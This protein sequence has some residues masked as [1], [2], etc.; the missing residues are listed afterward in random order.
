MSL[1]LCTFAVKR[2]CGARRKAQGSGDCLNE[3]GASP[4]EELAPDI[5][6]HKDLLR[7]Q[8]NFTE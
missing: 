3:K 6:K 2:E 8:Q 5:D 7:L 1:F 4:V